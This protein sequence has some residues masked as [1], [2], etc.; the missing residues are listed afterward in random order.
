MG[1]FRQE[2][3]SG[4]QFPS[5]EDLPNSGIEPLSPVSPALQGDS[6]LLEPP[7]PYKAIT[8]LKKS[9]L[10]KASRNASAAQS[11]GMIKLL[12]RGWRAGGEWRSKP[13]WRWGPQPPFCGDWNSHPSPSRAQA[14]LKKLMR[15]ELS[16]MKADFRPRIRNSFICISGPATARS[17]MEV[18][19]GVSVTCL[20]S[21][22]ST[23]ARPEVGR[24]LG[25]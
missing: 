7:Q 23:S 6:L 9:L 12:P 2:Y 1:F 3:R 18:G 20:N 13:S 15:C 11:Q 16:V 24:K 5:P 17:L 10:K 4:L 19:P 8:G 22:T 14:V 25:S 21:F